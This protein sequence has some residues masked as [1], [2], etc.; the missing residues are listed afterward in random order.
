M[1]KDATLGKIGEQEVRLLLKIERG[2]QNDKK[3]CG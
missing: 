1:S 3:E 2:N